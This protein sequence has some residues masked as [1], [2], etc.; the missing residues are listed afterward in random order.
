ME[1]RTI[2]LLQ[3]YIARRLTSAEADELREFVNASEDHRELFLTFVNLHKTE[4]QAKMLRHIDKDKA[5]QNIYRHISAR[6]NRR[7]TFIRIAAAV[8]LIIAVG[9][10]VYLNRKSGT[11]DNLIALNRIEAKNK[12]VI[13]MPGGSSIRLD[14]K[15]SI[16]YRDRDGNL[17]CENKNG[18]LIYYTR[19]AQPTFNRVEVDKGS[20]Y[21]ITLADGTHITLASGSELIYPIGGDERKVTLSG[22]AFFDVARDE[23]NP[24]TISCGNDTKVTVLGTK[25]NVSAYPAAP[26]CVTVES[27]SV[28]VT[29]PGFDTILSPG[30]QAIVGGGTESSV[31]TVDPHLFTSWASGI[32]EFENVPLSDIAAELS[33]WYG[34]DFEFAS[35]AL[36]NRKFT[37]V[38]LRDKNLSYT[39]SLIKDVSDLDFKAADQKIIIE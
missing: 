27:G 5:W 4:I 21:K 7:L 1:E 37:G 33:L 24:F 30:Q 2:Y 20:T 16:R 12:A 32:Y 31:N 29:A 8:V 17:V 23:A 28:N 36:E 15:E 10:G 14:S 22:E 13:T 9:A 25:F 11:T 6:P 26:V 19:M 34:V 18:D 35:P 38:L 3:R 39:L